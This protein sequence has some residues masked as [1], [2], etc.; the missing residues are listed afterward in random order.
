MATGKREPHDPNQRSVLFEVVA[1][2]G[3]LPG[4]GWFTIAWSPTRM[5][6]DDIAQAW[7]DKSG[8]TV[9]VWQNDRRGDG[10]ISTSVRHWETAP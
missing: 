6:A 2:N 5:W 9:E 3:D 10:W 8:Q 7:F 1:Y 4:S